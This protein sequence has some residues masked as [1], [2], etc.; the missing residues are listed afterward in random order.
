MEASSTDAGSARGQSTVIGTVLVIGLVFAGA[1]ALLLVGGPALSDLEQTADRQQGVNA[2]SQV[3]NRVS[4]VALG[5]RRQARVEFGDTGTDAAVEATTSGWIRVT[6]DNGTRTELVNQSL[7]TITR[8]A[9]GDR[10]A[11]QGGG[12]WRETDGGTSMVS[13]PEFHYRDTTLT[14]PIVSVSGDGSASGSSLLVRSSDYSQVTGYPVPLESGSVNVSVKSRYYGAWGRFFEDRTEGVV[15]YDHANETVTLRLVTPTDSPQVGGAIVSNGGAGTEMDLD[16]KTRLVS[17]NRSAGQEPNSG[18]GNSNTSRLI[19]TGDVKLNSGNVKISGDVLAGGHVEF[20]DSQP[21]I[22]GNVSCAT[23]NHASGEDEACVTWDSSRN[24]VKGDID[25]VDN[26]VR[27]PD[28]VSDLVDNKVRD[29]EAR[30]DNDATA[31]VSNERLN[32]SNSDGDTLVLDNGTYYLSSVEMSD[33][34][35]QELVLD[36]SDG[37]VELAVGSNFHMD[38][39]KIVVRGNGTVQTYALVSD[40]VADNDLD[41]TGASVEVH[42]SSGDRTYNATKFWLYAPAGIEADIKSGTDFTGVVYA[43]DSDTATGAVQIGDAD[44]NGAVVAHVESTDTDADI[45]FDEALADADPVRT[46][47]PN[48]PRVTFMHITVNELEVET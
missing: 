40:A 19:L 35:N 33:S 20:T 27:S 30:N 9:G 41:F 39:T 6:H 37:D 45:F 21:E 18:L 26:E 2:M 28:P 17:Y 23:G 16:D 12:V 36:T 3:D 46:A 22:K 4:A 44:V 1:S 5:D 29:V 47:R 43:P 11:Y 7:G 48:D 42:D 31:N 25:T 14:L 8:R 32:W 38:G 34:G 15:E 24:Q 13:P 10:V